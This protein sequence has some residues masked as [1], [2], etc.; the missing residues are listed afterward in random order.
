MYKPSLSRKW[1]HAIVCCLV[2][3]MSLIP[4]LVT[5]AETKTESP[6]AI[7]HS[8]ESFRQMGS[9]LYVAAHPDDENT[10][11][12]TYLARG[13]NYRT[14]Y[15]SLTRGDGG[16]NV[17]GSDL[18]E[19]LGLAR[20]HELLAARK[21][22]GA[23]QFFTRAVDFG[24]SKSYQETL[25]NWNKQEI[26]SD[27]VRVIRT[28]R[29]DVV[30]AR[31]SPIPGGTHG[32]HTASTILSM[33][34][35][36]LAGDPKAFPEQKLP[37]W[38]PK[39]LLWNISKWQKDKAVGIDS[40][41]IDV[42]G[43]D[44]SSG[45]R[46]VEIAEKSRGMHK[47][48]GFDTFQF[49]NGKSDPRQEAFHLLDGAAA[50]TDIMEG[51]DDT[52]KRVPGGDAIAN[53]INEVISH[54]NTQDVSASVPQLL[55]LSR[56]LQTLKEQSPIITEKRKQLDHIIQACLGLVVES[57]IDKAEVVPGEEM[58]L[59]LSAEANSKLPVRWISTRYPK[60]DREVKIG[61]IL[62]PGKIETHDATEALP[63]KT[64]LTQPYW[65]QNEGTAGTYKVDDPNLIGVAKN[66]SAFPVEYNFEIEGTKLVVTDTPVQVITGHSGK[67]ER[68]R[69]TV[70]PP[71]AMHFATELQLMAPGASRQVELEIKPYREHLK[72]SVKLEMP[73]GWSVEP[74][75]QSFSLDKFGASEK[76]KFTITAPT[77][78]GTAKIIASADILQ[79]KRY[80]NQRQEVKYA[81]LD[82]EF[83]HPQCAMKAVS[84]DV[85]KRGQTIG[86][87]PGAGDSL[88]EN[89]QEMGYTVKI[90]DDAKLSA[91]H[92]KNLDAI[93]LGVRAFNVR[94]HMA[95]AVP[96]LFDYVK[97]G[98]TL[99]VQYN[100][101]DG[102]KAPSVAPYDLHISPDRTTDEKAKMTFLEPD[103]PALNS[104]NKLTSADFDAWVQ[105][106]GLY[107]PNKWADEFTP[108]LA[109]GD[110]GETPSKGVLL[111]AKYGKGHYVYTGLSLFRQLPAGV[112][113]AYRLLA[114]LLSLGK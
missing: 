7:L 47:T 1:H 75:G 106:R 30:I 102:L 14:A 111:I 11:L 31:F 87:L 43:T 55:K 71:V 77:K 29:P 27:V 83:L 12:L 19:K 79:G 89:I 67:E 16:Q 17:L 86:Y 100:R 90:L 110:E 42:G 54:F 28:F 51:V 85:A 65:L 45:E 41:K 112:P 52:W 58:K 108:I 3:I 38:Q 78:P 88:P 37:A 21:L 9:V 34:A 35:F 64:P 113:G 13:R 73:V 20:T 15:L 62:H 107:F 101:P 23:Q 80:S 93:V 66:P 60:L 48:Q 63:S 91:E 40:F 24:F 6:K 32:H 36:K 59:H 10:E 98:G 22:D 103:S 18:G 56:Q 61:S 2:W 5:A 104:P 57:T 70:I 8:L 76:V 53:E 49:P 109:C 25:N 72:G 96:A 26:L 44:L 81:H 39:R 105:E 46:F 114:N 4:T 99:I 94:E 95:T 69:L 84:L 68:L 92:L 33:E 50:Q 82:T 74:R 97:D